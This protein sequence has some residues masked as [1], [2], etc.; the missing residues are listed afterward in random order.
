MTGDV[1]ER[2][3]AVDIY[4]FKARRCTNQDQH[5]SLQTTGHT[6]KIDQTDAILGF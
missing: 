3:Q 6:S 4:F 5:H 2:A 1:P